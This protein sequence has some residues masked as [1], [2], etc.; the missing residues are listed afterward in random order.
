MS[1][2]LI[3]IPWLH[4][5]RSDAAPGAGA[6]QADS[7]GEKVENERGVENGGAFPSSQSSPCARSKPP[8]R[9]SG[10]TFT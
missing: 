2:V 5:S 3:N 7:P 4:L 6:L 9:P 1:A 10:N 8:S